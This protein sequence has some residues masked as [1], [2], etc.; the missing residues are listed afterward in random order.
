LEN[1]PGYR[2][3][4]ETKRQQFMVETLDLRILRFDPETGELIQ[5]EDKLEAFRKSA[6]FQQQKDWVLK[7]DSDLETPRGVL[8]GHIEI[9]Q[10]KA[11]GFVG[12]AVDLVQV[13]SASNPSE[14]EHDQDE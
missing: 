1:V 12:R 4:K 5:A 7:T 6:W 14:Q 8:V 2:F 3:D 9:A 11:G 10:P 13:F